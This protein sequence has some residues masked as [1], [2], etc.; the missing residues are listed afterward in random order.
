MRPVDAAGDGFEKG[1]VHALPHQ[2]DIGHGLVVVGL[3]HQLQQLIA[4][5][6]VAQRP[7]IFGRRLQGLLLLDEPG[8]LGGKFGELALEHHEL[9]R[10][11]LV[12]AGGCGVR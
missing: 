9:L 5:Q 2:R 10:A 3:E 12:A 1:V 11:R 8:A 4:R 7:Q 6:L